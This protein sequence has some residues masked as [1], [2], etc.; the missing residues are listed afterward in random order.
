MS[1]GNWISTKKLIEK[2]KNAKEN[3]CQPRIVY[4]IKLSFEKKGKIKT[5]S[6]KQLP[7]P[8]MHHGVKGKIKSMRGLNIVS[9]YIS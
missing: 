8:Q 2:E 9:F 4:L 7:S 6:V 1:S 3:N 5:F